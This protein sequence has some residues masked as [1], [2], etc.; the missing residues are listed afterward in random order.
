MNLHDLL[1][2]VHLIDLCVL[3]AWHSWASGYTY[4]TGSEKRG[5][6]T[7]NANFYH[8]S[9]CHHAKAFRA[10]GLPLALQT[11]Q[12][13]YFTDPSMPSVSNSDLPKW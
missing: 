13:F 3:W 10:L 1:D 7:Q 8:F 9:N 4:V 6:F 12:A 11:L 5:H 2:S